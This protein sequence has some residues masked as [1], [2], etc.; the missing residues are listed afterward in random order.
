MNPSQ[1]GIIVFALNSNKD[2][3]EK[4]ARKLG[5]EL[6]SCSVGKFQNQETSVKIG[7]SVRGKD[8]YIIQSGLGESL[9]VN[10][11]LMELFILTYACKTACAKRIIG[12]I[13]YLPYSKQAKMNK[14]GS[15][16]SKLVASL[17]CR[18]G[19][20]NVIT[21]DL[22]SKEIQ[23]FYD[24]P[25]DNLRASPFLVHYITEKVA[26]YRNAVI[27]ARNPGSAIR[28]TSF[29]ERLRLG[30]AVIHG[31]QKEVESEQL[32]GRQSP[33]P[34]LAEGRRFASVSMDSMSL[35]GFLPKAKPPI[36]V[37]GDVGGKIAIIVDDMIDEA[38]SFV[39]AAK[40][41]KDRGAYKILVMVTHGLLSAD[42]P[43]LI[44][45]SVIDEVV[46]TNTVSH[47]TKMTRCSKIRTVDISSLLAEAIRR[48]HNGESMG[49]LFRNVPL[50]D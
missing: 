1:S 37:V 7:T 14:R 39:N 45:E 40:H 36:N 24:A 29:A 47:D 22:H 38:E 31:E 28:A 4:I 43:E 42:A 6:A 2:L 15:I 26:D 17:M 35:P 41:L 50:E 9:D 44:E 23:G 27:V 8:V 10:D 34:T 46:I 11:A 5:I 48:I 19:L 30:L 20:T 13:P 18:A 49:Y 3:S 21:V 33:P 12:V 16:P 32:D 25:V